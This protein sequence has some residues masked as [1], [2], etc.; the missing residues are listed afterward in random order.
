[1]D[2]IV[3]L[4][5][6]AKEL[7][8]L[9]AGHKTI[10]IRAAKEKRTPYGEV[11]EGDRLYFITTG[12]PGA[13]QARAKVKSVLNCSDLTE[14]ESND[15]INKYLMEMMLVEKQLNDCAGKPYLVLVRVENVERISPFMV[16][17]DVL[18]NQEDWFVVDDIDQ[19]K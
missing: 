5:S 9:I 14:T 10:I 12:R 13:V 16:D 8:R 15:L 18:E 1:M 11:S 19:V 17:D 7:E 4:D 2:H 6:D 3:Y